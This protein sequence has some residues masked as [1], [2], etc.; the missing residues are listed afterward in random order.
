MLNKSASC[1][2]PIAIIFH[3]ERVTLFIYRRA[4][5]KSSARAALALLHRSFVSVL[6]ASVCVDTPNDIFVTFIAR[7]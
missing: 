1:W 2:G 7:T 6:R 4:Q 3:S 5:N